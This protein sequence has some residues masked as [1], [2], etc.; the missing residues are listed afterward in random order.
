MQTEG[1]KIN[2]E[3]YL[4]EIVKQEYPDLPPYMIRL[5]TGLY[6]NPIPRKVKLQT[7]RMMGK[8]TMAKM[9]DVFASE[10]LKTH[11][12]LEVDKSTYYIMIYVNNKVKL[13]GN[14]FKLL[15]KDPIEI[16]KQVRTFTSNDEL[17]YK[18][19]GEILGAI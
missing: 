5:I 10:A 18:I 14:G 11:F 4:K 2:P 15:S 1:I 12:V 16:A 19:E 3:V 6:A 17:Y 13:Y 7:G 8:S 9:M